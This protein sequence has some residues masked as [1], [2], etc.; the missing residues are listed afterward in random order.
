[1]RSDEQK[2]IPKLWISILFSIPFL[3]SKLDPWLGF[4]FCTL[5]IV[6]GAFP[7]LQKGWKNKTG[8]FALVSLSIA[9]L[10]CYSIL[11]LLFSAKPTLYFADAAFITAISLIGALF[12]MRLQHVNDYVEM[13]L[14]ACSPKS[15]H[16]LSP[17]GYVQEIA[18]AKLE[19]GDKISVNAG[20]VIAADGIVISGSG[21]VDE[22]LV[23]GSMNPVEKV[24]GH[25]V[26]AGTKC[27]KDAFVVSIDKTAE[28]SFISKVS[29]SIK[30]ARPHVEETKVPIF[31]IAFVIFGAL[32]W[33]IFSGLASGV[34]VAASMLVT[35]NP[36]AIGLA[37]PLVVKRALYLGALQGIVIQKPEQLRDVSKLTDKDIGSDIDGENSFAVMFGG[38]QSRAWP[39]IKKVGELVKQ[40]LFFAWAYNIAVLFLALCGLISPVTGAAAHIFASLVIGVFPVRLK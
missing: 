20:D 5:V 38:D 1:V 26:F 10:Y 25:S 37:V 6:L 39:F 8:P 32:V 14:Q 33:S 28:T 12:E 36:R 27:V 29:K 13:R 7:I 2:L 30:S 40:S 16:K 15:V 9:L 4:L 18:T 31:I 3:G 17:D 22:S 11:A 35:V 21:F 19:P 24:F 23:T 34:Y